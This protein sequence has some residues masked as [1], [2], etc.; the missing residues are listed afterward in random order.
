MSESLSDDAAK[1]MA[2]LASEWFKATR[3]LLSLTEQAARS[4]HER[5][6]ARSAYAGGQ[7]ETAL[8]RFGL[9]LV[10]YEG[11]AFSPDLPAEPVNPEDF[12]TEDGLCVRETLEPT[13]VRDGRV[14]A[15]GRVVLARED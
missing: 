15:R 11:L 7:V 12:D 4:R 14:I 9:K 10:T 2:L 3:R 13:V 1:A 6:V 8:S 5:E